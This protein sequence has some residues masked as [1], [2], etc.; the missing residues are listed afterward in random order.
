MGLVSNCH[1]IGVPAVIHN[2]ACRPS[3]SENYIVDE[4]DVLIVLGCKVSLVKFQVTHKTWPAAMAL[5]KAVMAAAWESKFS[6]RF[7]GI[8]RTFS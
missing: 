3:T 4:V 8:L 2:I 5:R 7:L 6:R 1:A